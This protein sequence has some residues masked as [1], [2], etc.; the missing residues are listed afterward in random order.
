MRKLKE[1]IASQ[2]W[3]R[4]LARHHSRM[5]WRDAPRYTRYAARAQAAFRG[6]SVQ[7][8]GAIA[9]AAAEFNRQGYTWFHTEQTTA[10]ASAIQTKI[11]AQVAKL[12]DAAVWAPNT[13]YALGDVYQQFPEVDVLFRGVLGDFLRAAFGS[14]FKIFFGILYRSIHDPD[15]PSGSQVWHADG[16]PGTCINLMFCISDARPE[17]GSMEILPWQDSLSIF[18]SETRARAPGD[19]KQWLTK[20]YERTI[21]ERFAQSVAQ[22]D[23]GPGLVYP[24]MNNT[25]HRG[26]FPKNGHTRTVFV[27]HVY[28]SIEPPQFDAYR[29]HG[30]AK[31]S[32]FPVDP[33]QTF[34]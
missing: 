26:G 22:P 25:I 17:N 10:L 11:D 24:F 20:F 21:A 29:A 3:L 9:D 32:P 19:G 5:G 27:F 18:R 33:G 23:A 14:E 7:P 15:G 2:L 16:G 6:P 13:Q 34:G 30:I 12:G 31:T 4:T 28:P 1:A 8:P